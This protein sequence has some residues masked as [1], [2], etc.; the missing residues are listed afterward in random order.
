MTGE[1]WIIYWNEYT[2]DTY[3]YG[4]EI[5]FHRRDDVELV[6]HLLPSGTVIHQ[7]YSKTNFQVQRIEP[8][9]PMIDGESAYLVQAHIECAKAEEYLIRVIF[10]NRYDMEVDSVI[11]RDGEGTFQCPLSTYSYQIQLI[12]G[13]LTAFHFHN[14]LIKEIADETDEKNKAIK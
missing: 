3:L 12:S 10:F 7:W 8:S 5:I 9:L 13:G 2:A 6:N 11:I 14:I 1:Q 4:S